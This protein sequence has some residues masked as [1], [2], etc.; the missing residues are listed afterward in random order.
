[1]TRAG[2]ILL[3]L[4]LSSSATVAAPP[5]AWPTGL[6]SDVHTVAETGDLLGLET[7]FYDEGGRH[8]VE[9]AWCEG[10]CNEIYV[11]EVGRSGEGFAF[12]LT[13]A[14]SGAQGDQNID[15]RIVVRPARGG[16]AYAI[17]QGRE[18]IGK[19]ARMRRAAKPFG[20]AVARSGKP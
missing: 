20:L 19:P 1:V 9:I 6:Y 2:G 16:L 11:S 5:P 12:R 7:R 17:Y 8:M 3:G 10:W 13:Q 15:Y 18:I 14:A 4:L